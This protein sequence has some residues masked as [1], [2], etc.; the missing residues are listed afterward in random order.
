MPAQIAAIDLATSS[1]VALATSAFCELGLPQALQNG[2]RTPRGLSEQGWGNEGSLRRLLRALS[3]YD[4]VVELG[5]DRFALGRLGAALV[6]GKSSASSMIQYANAQWHLH[7]WTHLAQGIRRGKV[8]FQLAHGESFF[9]YCE[10]HPEAAKLFDEAMNA[11]VRLHA[12]AVVAAYDFEGIA[13]V[14]DLAGGHGVLLEAIVN[15]YP[16]VRATLFERP[17][18]AAQARGTFAIVPGDFFTDTPPAADAYVLSHV[19]HDWDDDSC[20]RILQ[21]V[22]RAMAPETRI[23]AIEILLEPQ[24]NVWSQDKVTDLEMLATLTGRERTRDEF[25]ALFQR[26]GL[27]LQRVIPTAAAESILEARR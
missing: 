8:P 21:S 19:L 10:Q 7:A 17:Q 9:A 4:V 13:H 14:V 2:A 3:G 23:L 11:V 5:N 27:R 24:R 6:P 25:V 20:V 1:W 18:V 12:D 16:A 15:R 22:R 26:S